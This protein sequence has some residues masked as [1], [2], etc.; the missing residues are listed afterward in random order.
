MHGVKLWHG[1]D[2]GLEEM[3]YF[4]PIQETLSQK[5]LTFTYFGVNYIWFPTYVVNLMYMGMRTG[6]VYTRFCFLPV[7]F[8]LFLFVN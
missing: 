2:E 5:L 1:L 4:K 7:L 8:T 6:Q 3:L